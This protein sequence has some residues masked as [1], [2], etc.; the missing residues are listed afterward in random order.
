MMSY[1]GFIRR[2]WPLLAF[3]FTAVFWGNFGQSFFVAW[4][5]AEIQRDLGLSAGAYGSA[6]SLATLGAAIV[7]VWAGGLIDRM[8]LRRFCLFISLG[9]CIAMLGLSLSQN[10]LML[11]LSFFLLRLFGQSLLPHTG[12]TTMSRYFSDGRGKAISLAMS[13]VP[14]GEIVLPIL[15]VALIAALGWQGTFQLLALGVAFVLIPTM[16][17]LLKITGLSAGDT[18]RVSGAAAPVSSELGS[19]EDAG[20]RELLTDYR[21]WLAL[22]GIMVNP[23]IITGVFIHQNFLV[24]SKGWSVSWLASCFIVYGVVHWLSSM[25]M[26]VLVD[27][28]KSAWLLPTIVAPTLCSI[29]VAA[30]MPGD[31]AALVMLSLLGISAGSGSPITGWLWPKV[32]G[33]ARLG[34]IRSMNM[35]LMVFS[36]SVSPILY[37]YFI[38]NGATAESLF[39]T[40]ALVITVALILLL[41]SYPMNTSPRQR[42]NR[43]KTSDKEIDL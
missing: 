13:A 25:V 22:P 23:F 37:G 28:L 6:Y 5:G 16:L 33:T 14:L 26:G 43:N 41:F 34:A 31:I 8:P 18:R 11:L 9:L 3:G 2:N 4:F 17:L 21:Y 30:Y 32:Y 12:M 10:L 38:D 36:T 42:I 29:L 19:P 15:A 24:D 1:L 7:V 27:R 39:G 40:S 35:A 20:R